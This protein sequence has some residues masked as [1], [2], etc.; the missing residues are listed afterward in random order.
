MRTGKRWPAAP[1]ASEMRPAILG[2]EQHF[3]PQSAGCGRVCV[4]CVCAQNGGWMSREARN[5]HQT[6]IQPRCLVLVLP[7]VDREL[8]PGT[9]ASAAAL[10]RA[11]APRRRGGA[12]PD[13][14]CIPPQRCRRAAALGSSSCCA[15]SLGNSCC[16]RLSCSS[17]C[18]RA[19]AP[20]PEPNPP[21][22]RRRTEE[23]SQVG[24]LAS[25]RAREGPDVASGGRRARRR[26]GLH[27]DEQ[28][29]R[30]QQGRGGGPWP[31]PSPRASWARA[32]LILYADS[33]RITL[34]CSNAVSERAALPLC[35]PA[36]I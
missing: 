11:P 13:P 7:R 3:A 26:A 8:S 27:R 22:R 29:H 24:S 10:P 33:R 5:S 32:T 20:P 6:T 35:P 19:L 18:S 14:A 34:T 36:C 9:E 15:R 16:A 25:Q 12:P 28:D 2:R 30:P 4:P 31:L 21:R 17:C 23:V 1:A